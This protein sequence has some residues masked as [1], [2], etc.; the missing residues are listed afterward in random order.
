MP[1]PEI[2]E[3]QGGFLVTLFKDPLTEDQLINLGLTN[4]QLKAVAFV[5]EKGRITN[6]EYQGLNK[7]SDRTAYRELEK[8]TE[9]NILVKEGEKKGTYYKLRI[10]RYGG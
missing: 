2:K 9:L 8:L 3:F 6:S 4:R 5:K 7:T 1:E 10:G